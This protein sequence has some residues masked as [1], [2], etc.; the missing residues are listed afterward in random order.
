MLI[1]LRNALM[2]GKRTPTA[3]DYVQDGLQI[4]W[5]AVENV[6]Y[7]THDSSAANWIDL[8]SGISMPIRNTQIWSDTGLYIPREYYSFKT[9][10]VPDAVYAAIYNGLLGKS[11]TYE[12]G[13]T[14]AGT[15]Y[16]TGDDTS[17]YSPMSKLFGSNRD[18][19][20]CMVGAFKSNPF[21]SGYGYYWQ[22]EIQKAGIQN[23]G[24]YRCVVDGGTS[25][26]NVNV[27]LYYNG[28]T[29]SGLLPTFTTT[30]EGTWANKCASKYTAKTLQLFEPRNNLQ[31]TCHYIRLYSR[32][33]SAAECAVND[34]V[35][36]ALFGP[37]DAT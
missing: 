34:A 18:F 23:G 8:A 16:P 21:A 7:G 1:N 32:A 2:T 6:A 15:T 36:E 20:G 14:D 28:S 30:V 9:I 4:N 33:L 31:G 27:R 24:H 29:T 10:T 17:A 13:W 35:D 19:A 12:Y 26:Y 3:K 25:D 22:R 11:F 5:N 37:P